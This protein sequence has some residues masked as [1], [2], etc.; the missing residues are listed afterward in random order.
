[1][2]WEYAGFDDNVI[3]LHGFP[4]RPSFSKASC[5]VLQLTFNV[6]LHLSPGY[7]SWRFEW[8]QDTYEEL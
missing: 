3:F 2:H 1:M 8:G 5:A 6:W 7:F 4:E